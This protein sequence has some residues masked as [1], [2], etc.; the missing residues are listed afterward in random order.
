MARM[1]QHVRSKKAIDRDAQVLSH[2]VRA[3]DDSGELRLPRNGYL[4]RLTPRGKLIV[5][6]LVRGA[7]R[8][9]AK[10]LTVT[11]GSPSSQAT[12]TQSL[13]GEEVK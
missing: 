7:G 4:L 5:A 2:T 6:P 3:L 13:L 9:V 11:E 8:R 1:T 10:I 12:T